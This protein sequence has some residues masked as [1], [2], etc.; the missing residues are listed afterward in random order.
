[1]E[2]REIK[3]ASFDIE[4]SPN[5]GA[6]FELYR[7][8]NILWNIQHWNIMSFAI[9]DLNNKKTFVYALPD[10]K[11]YKTQKN[12]DKELV[13][14]LWKIFN[15]YD[16][17]I[18]HNGASF[19]MKK[20]MARFIYHNML[21]PN[22]PVIIDTKL[23]AKRYF[24]FDSNKLDDLGDYLGIGRKLETEKNL[25][26]KCLDGDLKAWNLMKKYNIQDVI[27]L[28]KVYLRLLPYI[29]NHPNYAMYLGER[30]ACPNCGS[31]K[32]T[33]DGIRPKALSI[34]QKWVCKDCGARPTS[35]LKYNSQVR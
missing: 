11:L 18:A 19:D 26:K 4:T 17:L 24:K 20:V 6:Y 9:K 21:P 3:I 15:E 29:K 35:P 25:W 12:N 7:E 27:L 8:G 22:I 13:K 31:F 1:M 5:I 23:V 32:L 14:I 33:K 16:V 10:F 34:V 28:E 2:K 30:I